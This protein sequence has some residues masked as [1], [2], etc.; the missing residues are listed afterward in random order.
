MLYFTG[1]THSTIDWYKVQSFAQKYIDTL[2]AND[3]LFIAGD[4]GGCWDN[5]PEDM[6]VLDFYSQL[7]FT[8]CFVDGNHENFNIIYNYPI[9][10]F[11]GGRAHRIRPNLYHLI[12]GEVFE[13]EGKKILAM[14]GAASTDKASRIENKSWWAEEVPSKGQR[15]HCFEK[16]EKNDF[17]VDIILTHEMPAG[18]APE[19]ENIMQIKYGIAR[20]SIKIRLL[21][22]H[23]YSYWLEDVIHSTVNYKLWLFGHYHFDSK[24]GDKNYVMYNNIYKLVIDKDGS[25]DLELVE[26][27]CWRD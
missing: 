15:D 13:F 12:R 4:F 27:N 18:L 14:G 7:N 19:M 11:H 17:N 5:G 23:E 10:E 22:P 3:T 16:L 9:V 2:T 1:D 24:I 8:V 20:K 6:K 26:R 25:L 21:N